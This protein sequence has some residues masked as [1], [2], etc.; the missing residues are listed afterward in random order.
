MN[1]ELK[2]IT[3]GYNEQETVLDNISFSVPTS[4]CSAIVGS[5]GS[6]KST[7]LRLINGLLQETNG[8]F[9]SGEIFINDA[10]IIK[11]KFVWSNIRSKG[12]LGFMFQES[13]LLPHLSVEHNINF[14]LKVI[15]ERNQENKTVNDYLKITGLINHKNKLP[16]ELS[17]GMKTRVALARTFI[18]KPELLLLDEPFSSLDI[19]WKSKLYKEVKKLKNE[20]NTTVI[21]VTHDIFEAIN[22]SKNI[23]VLG[24]NHKIIKTLEINGWSDVLSYN[25]VVLKFNKEFI[26]I[27]ELIEQSRIKSSL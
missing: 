4:S 22:F 19:V 1:V 11:E 7:I 14:P 15:G 24:D 3:F 16:K 27:K 8:D 12:K 25:D 18:T 21:L 10:N 23:I 26:K 5:S 13:N 17:G 9:L 6:G 20:H 2:N